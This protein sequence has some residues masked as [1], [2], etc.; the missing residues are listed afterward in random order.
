MTII[1]CHQS[2]RKGPY[3][4][5]KL[6]RIPWTSSMIGNQPHLSSR[7]RSPG[8]GKI[9]SQ[10]GSAPLKTRIISTA[11]RWV[12]IKS[13]LGDSKINRFI[14]DPKFMNRKLYLLS[15]IGLRLSKTPV[16]W[17]QYSAAG[18]TRK[19]LGRCCMKVRWSARRSSSPLRFTYKNSFI[20]R[21]MDFLPLRLY[22][23]GV[24]KKK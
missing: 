23:W 16:V 7:G 3:F 9:T 15:L 11:R 14:M 6:A 13:L 1:G 2:H 19:A 17:L 18:I 12:D 8:M 24:N 21:T 5:R 22:T 4:L 20:A 10:G